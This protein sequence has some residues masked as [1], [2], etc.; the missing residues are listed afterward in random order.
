MKT[1]ITRPNRVRFLLPWI[2]AALYTAL[3]YAL[4]VRSGPLPFV[5]SFGLQNIDKA[6]HVGAYFVL[7]FILFEALSRT[8]ALKP[9]LKCVV[10]VC[11]LGFLCGALNEFSQ[12]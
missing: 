1:R 12:A 3:L 11:A 2:P 8:T 10:T 4:S 9:G 5:S 7:G 6:Y